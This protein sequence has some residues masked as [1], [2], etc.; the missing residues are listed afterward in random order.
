M[1]YYENLFIVNPNIEQE[2][3]TQLIQTVKA[4]IE[5]L[6]GNILNLED[7]GKRRLAYP[8]QKHRYGSY[9]LVQFETENVELVKELE[10]WFRLNQG[11]LAFMTVGLDEKPSPKT[12]QPT[13]QPVSETINE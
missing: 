9:V 13:D 2:K 5:R 12:T 4:E 1:R 11:I 6:S 3:F 7:W 10:S 8:I